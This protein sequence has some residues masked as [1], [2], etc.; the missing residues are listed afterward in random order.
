MGVRCSDEALANPGKSVAQGCE[1]EHA[2]IGPSRRVLETTE[3]A[4]T[5]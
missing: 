2:E 1:I 4:L 5:S 3:D